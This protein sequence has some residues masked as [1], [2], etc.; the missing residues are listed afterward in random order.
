[1][2][3][4]PWGVAEQEFETSGSELVQAT[5]DARAP[6]GLSKLEDQARRLARSSR[7]DSTWR[8]Y[9]SD[10]RH[11]QAWCSEH[12][13][14]ALPAEPPTVATYLAALESPHKPST[15]R[16]RLAAISL[17]HQLVGLETPTADAVVKSVWAGIR[18]RKG[19]APRKVRAA[20]TNVITT[21]PAPLGNRLIDVR[22]RTLI[23]IGFAGTLRRS[24]LIALDV[25]DVP[26][27]TIRLF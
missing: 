14:S 20:H 6:M 25:D 7:A 12:H 4:G 19:I 26:R 10:F 9:D 1:M 15:I 16:R 18:R 5:S 22:D 3:L 23:L 24:E 17:S 11:F 2:R 8:A 21:L 27:T 13:L